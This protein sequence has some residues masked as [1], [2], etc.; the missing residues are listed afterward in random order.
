MHQEDIRLI[1]GRTDRA[2]QKDQS[3]S[4]PR[5]SEDQAGVFAQNPSMV[6][7]NSVACAYLLGM[8]TIK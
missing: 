2:T 7:L 6:V 5:Y 3:D 4:C 1:E 8:D